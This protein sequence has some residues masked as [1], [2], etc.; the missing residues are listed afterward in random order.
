MYDIQSALRRRA[1]AE[2]LESL[3]EAA[4]A[5]DRAAG[6]ASDPAAHP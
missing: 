2:R 3:K 4:E 5:T 1:L 6:T